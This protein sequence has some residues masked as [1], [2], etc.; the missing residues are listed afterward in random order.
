MFRGNRSFS[1]DGIPL[2]FKVW[3][4]FVALMVIMVFGIVGYI[5]YLTIS[6]ASD[7][8]T[9]AQTIGE[10]VKTFREASGL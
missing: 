2:F 4:G 8:V 10:T 5:F 7:P 1:N 3:F 9:A 6:F